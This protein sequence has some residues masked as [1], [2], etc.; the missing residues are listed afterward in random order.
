MVAAGDQITVKVLRVDEAT[1]K[2]SLGLKQLQDDPWATSAAAY[3]VGQVH[4]GRVTR[5]ADFGAFVEL[6]PGI[7]GLAHASTFAPTGAARGWAKAV[8]VGFRGSF[9]IVSIDLK[10][11]RIGLALLDEGSARATD[12]ASPADAVAEAHEPA[13]WRE[14][15]SSQEATTSIT[16]GSLAD[17][18]REALRQR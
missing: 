15:E 13:E 9:E 2:I 1:G 16:S 10:Q 3:A 17:K 18:L 8:P 11:K 5:V 6:A 7:E 4:S 14:H 12:S